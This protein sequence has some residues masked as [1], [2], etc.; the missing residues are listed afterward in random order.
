M[1]GVKPSPSRSLL[2]SSSRSLAWNGFTLW[3]GIKFA[4]VCHAF[5]SDL[6]QCIGRIANEF[7]EEDLLVAVEGIGNETEKLIDLGLRNK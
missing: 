7:T 2:A 6:I 1:K 4:H 5:K 3:L